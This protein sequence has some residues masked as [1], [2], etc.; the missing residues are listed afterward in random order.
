MSALIGPEELAQ[1]A[2][3]G[4]YIELRIGF[5]AWMRSDLLHLSRVL[6]VNT[7]T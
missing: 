2:R 6:T 4:H 3:S 1:L 7:L 5:A